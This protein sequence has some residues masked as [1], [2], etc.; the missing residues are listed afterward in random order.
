LAGWGDWRTGYG[1]NLGHEAHAPS[2]QR[3]SALVQWY[4][5]NRLCSWNDDFGVSTTGGHLVKTSL[6]GL[7]WA[8][9]V[10][11]GC[12]Q[13]SLGA[14]IVLTTSTLNRVMVVELALPAM[15]PGFLVALHHVVQLARPRIGHGSDV[16]GRRTPWIVGG[17]LLL[18][19]SGVIAASGTALMSLSTSWGTVVCALGFIGIGLGS[20]AT[21]TSLLVLLA[22]TVSPDRKPAAATIVW[23]MMIAGFA[24]TAGTA[25][26][27]L[28]PYTP[29]RLISVTAIVSLLAVLITGFAI[30]GVE[31]RHQVIASP[32][33]SENKHTTVHF[34]E[35]LADVWAE[36]A[37]RRF[38]VFVFLSMLAYSF[39]DLILE[40]FAGL[41]F[42]MSPGQS[43]QL[44]GTQHGGVLLG[45][46][47]VAASGSLA[48]RHAAQLLKRW[49]VGGCIASGLALIGIAWGGAHPD[50]WN[51]S[52]NVFFLGAANGAFAVAAIAA[53][54]TL[55][56]QGQVGREGLRMG[57]WGAAQAIAFAAGGFLGTVAV[58]VC[59][60]WV[61]DPAHAYGLVFLFEAGLFLIAAYLGSAVGSLSNEPASTNTQPIGFG[62][63][64]LQEI[65]E[66]GTS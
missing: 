65:M 63:V 59:R 33:S 30:R 37:A 42:D 54:M 53:M 8:G 3:A 17:M 5:R 61:A 7:G 21:G 47:A 36:S 23:F 49:I 22:K 56:S 66:G 9:I 57:L 27:F 32:P 39:Q 6:E 15:L 62:D 48:K 35:A 52:A 31:I 34:R 58:D 24:I 12:I 44:S 41:A 55:A 51:L 13:A 50:Q 29:E 1:T 26:A 46:L 40:P 25:G 4:W 18:A 19:T 60:L 20:G 16:G 38:T 45:M 14:I 10:R 11:L 43:T 2:T 28:D 64:A